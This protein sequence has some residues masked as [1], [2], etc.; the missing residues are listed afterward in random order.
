[1]KLYYFA[2]GCS[3]AAH[4]ALRETGIAPELHEVDPQTR[5]IAGGGGPYAAVN[6]K[7]YVPAL[8]FDDGSMLTE[9]VAILDW[10]AD[11]SDRLRPA[12][13]MARTRQIEMLAFMSTEIHKMFL[14]LFFMP[15][16][17]AKPVI[18]QKIGERFGYL[19]ERLRGDFLLDERFSVADA[20]LYVML[21]WAK[22]SDL[23][24]PA[25]FDTYIKRIE[26][27]GSVTDALAAEGIRPALKLAG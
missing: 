22:M 17:E 9:N 21:R 23:E 7:G 1:M 19:A 24:V 12:P 2:D 18:R 10:I 13:G 4:I 15:G 25:V 6:P 27:R 20:F 3:L 5:Q 16:E 26:R 14:S 11:Q 8:V